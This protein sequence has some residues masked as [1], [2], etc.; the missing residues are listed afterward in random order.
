MLGAATSFGSE[1][2][3]YLTGKKILIIPHNDI[4]GQAALPKWVKELYAF[5]AKSVVSQPLPLMHD[6]LND[7]LQN[8]GPDQPLDLLKG[9]LTHADLRTSNS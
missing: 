9:F 3:Q 2:K 5:G 7:F 6:D 1:V 8:P 4:A